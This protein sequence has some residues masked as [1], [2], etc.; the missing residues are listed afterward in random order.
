MYKPRFRIRALRRG[1]QV[2]RLS[3]YEFSIDFFSILEVIVRHEGLENRSNLVEPVALQG[4]YPSRVWKSCTAE[5][6]LSIATESALLNLITCCEYLIE[7]KRLLFEE[8]KKKKKA[9]PLSPT[10]FSRIKI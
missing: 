9:S 1:R 3:T 8:K 4:Q 7:T 5:E 2:A 10:N 6:L